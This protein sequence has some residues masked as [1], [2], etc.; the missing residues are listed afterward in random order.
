MRTSL[1]PGSG[2]GTSCIQMPGSGR[3]FTFR[4]RVTDPVKFVI[5]DGAMKVR[6]RAQ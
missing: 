3:D 1:I 5:T 6:E 2:I 4:L